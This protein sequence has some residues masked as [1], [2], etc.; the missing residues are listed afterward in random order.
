MA[1]VIATVAVGEYVAAVE[2]ACTKLGEGKADEFRIEV[3]V[4]IKKIYKPKTKHH[5]RRKSSLDK[6]EERPF[7]DGSDS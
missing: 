1:D 2:Q 4:A 5:K 3:K 6:V 7:Q